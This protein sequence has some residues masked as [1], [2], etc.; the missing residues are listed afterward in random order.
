M[1]YSELEG[2]DAENQAAAHI[3]IAYSNEF[4]TEHGNQAASAICNTMR[5]ETGVDVLFGQSCYIASDVYEGDYTETD[6][7]YLSKNDGGWL[8]RTD[9]TGEQLYQL[10]E[11]TLAL[12]SNRGAVCND[13]TLY[14]SSGFEMDITR[15]EDGYTLNK[16]TRDGKDL[17]RNATYSVIIY[18]DRDWYIPVVQE[19]VGF[20]VMPIETVPKAIELIKQRLVENKG[21]LA[22]PT[23]YITIK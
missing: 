17:D 9:L 18:G 21:Q 13:S 14:V 3:D 11:E 12:K 10:V 23:D 22:K 8:V 6:V 16:L 1:V 20:E 4:T 5:E 2:E 7:E 15:T 19:K